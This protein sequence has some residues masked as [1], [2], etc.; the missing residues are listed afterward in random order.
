MPASRIPSV[1]ASSRSASKRAVVS[2]GRMRPPPA[3]VSRYSSTTGESNKVEPSSRMS[4]GTLPSGFCV[5]SGSESSCVEAG[6]TLILPSRPSTLTAMR[7]LR[8]NGEPKL[9]RS[10]TMGNGT[11]LGRHHHAVRRMFGKPDRALRQAPRELRSAGDDEVYGL[12]AF[13]FLVGLDIEGDA[14]PL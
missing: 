7:A 9:V 12:G 14:L 6:S 2:F 8:P 4:T 13:A 5:G 10:V 3:S 1:S 11:L